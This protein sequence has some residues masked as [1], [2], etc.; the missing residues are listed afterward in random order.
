MY[1]EDELVPLS[2]LQHLVFCERQCAMIHI[3]RLWLENQLTAEGRLMHE[4][5]HHSVSESRGEVHLE[6]AVSL[7][8]LRLG[9][10]GQA[11]VVEFYRDGGV[12]PVEYKRGKPKPNHCDEVQLCA[13]AICLEEMLEVDVPCGALFYGKNRRRKDIRFDDE[14]RRKTA[15]AAKR[16]HKLFDEEITPSAQYSSKCKRCSFFD[17]CMPQLLGKNRSVSEY[18]T[19]SLP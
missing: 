17:Q 4:R 19:E 18:L 2:A 9:L 15:E 6:F 7:R 3:E 10:S 12:F 14:L 11:D 5:V 13:Q 8:S 1:A 16:V